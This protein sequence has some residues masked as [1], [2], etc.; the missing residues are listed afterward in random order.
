MSPNITAQPGITVYKHSLFCGKKE[1]QFPVCSIIKKNGSKQRTVAGQ[2]EGG[3]G[4]E[5]TSQPQGRLACTDILIPSDVGKAERTQVRKN[6]HK[7]DRR[8]VCG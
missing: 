5:E 2:A 8:E 3:E 6:H 7:K 4:E 1:F